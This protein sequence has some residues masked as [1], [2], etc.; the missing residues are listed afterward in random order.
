MV[1]GHHDGTFTPAAY[2]R[3]CDLDV[4]SAS[5]SSQ[6]KSIQT[7]AL[8]PHA[9][10]Q[11]AHLDKNP[12]PEGHESTETSLASGNIGIWAVGEAAGP[13]RVLK[14]GLRW[15]GARG[16]RGI[17]P[18]LDC[19]LGDG[20]PL[21]LFP[22][23]LILGQIC[24]IESQ[25]IMFEQSH[26]SLDYFSN[27][28]NHSSGHQAGYNQSIADYFSDIASAGGSLSIHDFWQHRKASSL[29]Y[30]STLFWEDIRTLSSLSSQ[31]VSLTNEQ[32]YHGPT[33]WT[34]R[35]SEDTT[36]RFSLRTCGRVQPKC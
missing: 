9:P 24:G 34:V 22:A 20:N 28:L 26:S 27:D 11:E 13:P 17:G 32:L 3:Q 30:V 6:P 14:P 31:A 7:H 4:P 8:A 23:L 33:N 18:A 15:S 35:V 19:P 16:G 25:T 36:R 2:R 10:A 21:G 5:S 29:Q 12:S 1:P